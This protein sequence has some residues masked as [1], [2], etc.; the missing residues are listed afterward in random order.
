[1]FDP[2]LPKEVVDLQREHLQN[3]A[4]LAT[5]SQGLQKIARL[6]IGEEI[7]RFLD[8]AIAFF[9]EGALYAVLAKPGDVRASERYLASRLDSVLELEG[10]KEPLT[11]AQRK[12]F[13]GALAAVLLNRMAVRAYEQADSTTRQRAERA[14]VY[15]DRASVADPRSA[16]VELLRARF[17]VLG[18]FVKEARASLKRVRT[19]HPVGDA[20]IAKDVTELSKALD[21]IAKGDDQAGDRVAETADRPVVA[22]EVQVRDLEA[23]LADHP[24]DIAAYEELVRLLVVSGD[25]HRA[26]AWTRLALTRCLSAGLQLRARQLDLE[27]LALRDLAGKDREAVGL[28]LAGGHVAVL[29]R[30]GLSKEGDTPATVDPAASYALRWLIGRCQLGGGDASAARATLVEALA[31]CDVLHHRAVLRRLVENFDGLLLDQSR[32]VV[33]EHVRK[34]EFARASALLLTAAAALQEP[35]H[36]LLDLARV[37]LAAA[38]RGARKEAGIPIPPTFPTVPWRARLGAALAGPSPAGRARALAELALESHPP[39]ARD[40][41]AVLSRVA[42]VEEQMQVADAVAAATTC[43]RDGKMKEGLALL[44]ALP[45]PLR[46]APAALKARIFLEL[47]LGHFAAA[48][49]LLAAL[50]RSGEPGELLTQYPALRLKQQVAQA[51]AQLSAGDHAA[52]WALLADARPTTP[53][54]AVSVAY[55][56]AFSRALAFRVYGRA[57]KKSEAAAAAR[58]ALA[59]LDPVLAQARALDRGDVLTLHQKLDEG[60][61]RLLEDPHARL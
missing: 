20:E 7:L 30:L 19:L 38:M 44:D 4:D 39:S 57:G 22:R 59:L 2:T 52:A 35:A 37:A 56:R 53:E 58:E 28:F 34:G 13:G 3:M 27:V 48:D 29:Q 14:L 17:L 45:E 47:R 18:R 43:L 42:T 46:D 10:R 49:A 40:A 1:M 55:A 31:A 8:E 24:Q 26:E 33:D 16:W 54:E 11:W 6:D 21:D 61:D 5:L 25:F 23:V 9:D 36:V 50:T 12:R 32:A 15:V 41:R 51:H 60:V